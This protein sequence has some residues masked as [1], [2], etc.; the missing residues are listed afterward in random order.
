VCYKNIR[1][2]SFSFYTTHASDRLTDRQIDTQTDGQNFDCNT[3]HCITCSRTVK[4]KNALF[5]PPFLDLGVTY[6][7]PTPSI[8]RWKARGRLYIHRNWTFF[9]SPTVET[10]WAE[11]GRS[12]RFWKRGGSLWAQIS[13]GNGHR[14]LT[15]IVGVRKLEWLPFRVVWNG[16]N[17][18]KMIWNMW[19]E[20]WKYLQSSV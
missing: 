11:N 10:L 20:L 3:V 18:M 15:M 2:P 17:G 8:A 19:Y 4:T 6:P 7:V 5:E 16:M 14:L 13:E 1:S 9:R 12:R